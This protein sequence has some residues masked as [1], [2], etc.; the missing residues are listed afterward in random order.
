MNKD[1]EEQKDSTA[2]GGKKASSKVASE[3]PS[4]DWE[5]VEGVGPVVEWLKEN[6]MPILVGL[7]IAALAFSGWSFYR[8][9]KKTVAITA[10]SMLFNAQSPAQFTEIMSKYPDAPTAP[11]AALSLGTQQY[12]EGQYDQARAT[13]AE[14]ASKYPDHPL[15]SA[16]KL[17][18]AYCDEAQLKL[19][20]ALKGYDNFAKTE[21]NSFLQVQAI[22]GKG[23]CLE[24]L[25]R[26]EDARIVY[27]DFI[28]A[29]P[30]SP[31]SSRAETALMYVGKARRAVEKAMSAKPP[32]APPPPVPPSAAVP[33]S[34]PA[35]A[36]APEI[37]PPAAAPAAA[38]AK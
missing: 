3:E 12:D 24:Q 21:T 36:P 29:N 17:G 26:F 33:E 6:G 19:E 28:A 25:G 16:A 5:S 11:L 4:F 7:L 30:R 38:P 1:T 8:S 15:A 31:W 14:F 37:A 23:R 35:A 20:E 32:V 34:K 22:F 18:L 2:E 13:Y 10:E 27:E 9:H